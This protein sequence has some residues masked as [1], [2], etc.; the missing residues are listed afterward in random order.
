MKSPKEKGSRFERLICGRLSLWASD[1]KREDVFWRSAISGGRATFRKRRALVSVD[2]T[3]AGDVSAIH[4]LGFPLVERFFIECKHYR[5]LKL[6]LWLLGKKGEREELWDVPLARAIE[7]GREPLVIARQNRCDELVITTARGA[8]ILRRGEKEP[9]RFP[10][11]GV[12]GRAHFFLLREL[13][14]L[15]Y[16]RMVAA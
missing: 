4:P 13:L 2:A 6:E 16:A 8:E 9:G 15:D 3:S 11:R 5:E 14:D 7:L 1:L 12:I 10:L